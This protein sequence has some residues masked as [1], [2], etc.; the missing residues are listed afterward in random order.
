MIPRRKF[1]SR[2]ITGTMLLYVLIAAASAVFFLS[3]TWGSRGVSGD[4]AEKQKELLF[5]ATEG[6]GKIDEVAFS[7]DYKDMT[8]Q[9]VFFMPDA[10]KMGVDPLG[11]NEVVDVPMI[12]KHYSVVVGEETV[13]HNG[14]RDDIEPGMFVRIVFSGPVEGGAGEVKATEVS[15]FLDSEPQP[16]I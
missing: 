16:S 3:E 5:N 10:Q 4:L 11:K 7:A 12:E 15:L 8:M 6:F 1:F 9:V 14:E 2:L 13:I